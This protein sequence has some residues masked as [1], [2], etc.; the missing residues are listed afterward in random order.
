LT[1]EIEA[2]TGVK[3]VERALEILTCFTLEAPELSLYEICAKTGLPKATVHRLLSTLAQAKFVVQDPSSSTYRLGYKMMLM[4]AVAQS[5]INYL[6]KAEPI[7]RDLVHDIDETVAVASLDG[8]QHVCTLVVEP[9]RPVRVTTTL[10][11]RRPCYFGAAGSL[12]LAYQTDVF[13]DEI[14][15]ADKLEAFTVWSITDPI[16]YRRRLYSIHEHGYAIERGEAFPDVTAL[17]TP[18]IDH[19]G[20]VVATATII[21]PTHRVPDE[22]VSVLLKK[23]VESSSMISRELGAIQHE[24]ISTLSSGKIE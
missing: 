21:A 8:D 18:I 15:P 19:Q 6:S 16:E 2:T 23:L 3:A 4:G 12:L 22:R 5:Q 1:E 10:G 14:L 20:K 24:P 11:V 7:L 17:A 13:L 9:E